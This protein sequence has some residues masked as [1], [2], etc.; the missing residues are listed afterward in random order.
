MII[1]PTT[2]PIFVLF[3]IETTAEHGTNGHFVIMGIHT[4][5]EPCQ[6]AGDTPAATR[7][8]TYCK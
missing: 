3:G 2:G 6:F 4:E 5:P 7:G 8:V 1:T